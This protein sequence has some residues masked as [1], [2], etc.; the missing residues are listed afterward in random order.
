MKA[1]K[2]GSFDWNILSNVDS[3]SPEK[4]V[5][6][7]LVP[8]TFSGTHEDWE[9]FLVPEDSDRVKAM[10][11]NA[12]KTGEFASE[13]RI[14][15]RDDGEIRWMSTRAKVVFD[16]D[17]QPARMVGINIDITDR[18]RAEEEV[19]KLNRELE[20]RVEKRTV[21]LRES[22]QSVRRKL[23][24]IL[25]PEGDLSNL[26]L[27]DL[28]DLPAIQLLAEDFYRLAHIPM[29]VVDLRGKSLV[30]VGWQ[31]ICT[32]F[33]RVHPDT[34]KNC[35]ESDLV[36]SDGVSPGSFKLYKCKNNMWDVVTPITVGGQ[37]V[38]N[39]FSGQFFFTDEPLDYEAF[40]AQAKQH[41]F[42]END[43]IA[44]LE[45]APRLS[46]E[47]VNSG[48]EF[49]VK[50]SHVLSQ[51]SYSSIKLARSMAEISRVNADL[52]AS[53]KELEAF[54]YSVSHDLRAPLRHIGGFSKILAEEFGPGLP[55][56]ARHHLQRIEEGTLRMGQLVD[57]LLNLARVGRRD[58]SLQVT[59]LKAVIEEVIDGLKPEM[60]DRQIEWRV[61]NLSYV[62]CDPGLM[63]QVF[64]NLL[65]NAVKFTRPR[66][67]AVIEIG[68]EEQDGTR[69]IYVRD[70]GVGFSMKYVDK[71]F[72][73]FQ[74]L[75]RVEDFEGTGVGLATVQRIIQKHGGHI[76]A[77]AELEKGATFYFTLG[78]SEKDERHKK[79]VK[80]EQ[81]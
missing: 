41:G 24:S 54:T 26:E 39:L 77:E 76:W 5:L 47:A 6:Y 46:R 30:A 21:Q 31:D 9:S 50:F 4:E 63:K 3:W 11:Q 51:V 19:R 81:A 53:V 61:G 66:P 37:H 16:E 12:F 40:R 60:A 32:K 48:M 52:A 75:H 56:E 58:L 2:S 59:G 69:V 1:G 13:F 25:S 8:G 29:F 45:R 80:G 10:I 27:A 34:C 14:R 38:G 43:Y 42:N 72:G 73:V 71:L 55:E 7:G 57:D 22:E 79:A 78:N 65:S 18:V 67:Q 17:G 44:A 33:H 23:D 35:T 74:R 28:L 36:L 49:F 15:R 20:E 64:Q 70:N 62:D 68:Q